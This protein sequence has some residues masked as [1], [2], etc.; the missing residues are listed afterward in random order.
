MHTAYHRPS[1]LRVASMTLVSRN[2]PVKAAVTPASLRRS[3]F[4]RW[5]LGA[6]W[7]PT[8][9]SRSAT[10]RGL[11]TESFGCSSARRFRG[12]AWLRPAPP[13]SGGRSASSVPARQSA[14]RGGPQ[15]RP[16]QLYRERRTGRH[17]AGH[18]A[19]EHRR[20]H[21][22][23]SQA[24]QT[25]LQVLPPAAAPGKRSGLRGWLGTQTRRGQARL[26]GGTGAVETCRAPRRP[27]SGRS[28]EVPSP[29]G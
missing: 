11:E 9:A 28:P 24:S 13:I 23:L 21:H 4:S 1:R 10:V 5:P 27:F 26:P 3:A 7:R 6:P 22:V 20:R 8:P 29:A 25:Q 16:G 12:W 19:G 17:L 15:T 14:R 18:R 2:R